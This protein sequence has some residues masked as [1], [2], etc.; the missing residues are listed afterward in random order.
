MRLYGIGKGA[1][2]AQERVVSQIL[3]NGLYAHCDAVDCIADVVE[4]GIDDLQPPLCK[5]AR[6]GFFGDHLLRDV[7]KSDHAASNAADFVEEGPPTYPDI[8][9]L[10]LFF[11]AYEYV[12][13]VGGLAVEY[14]AGERQVLC[15]DG[16]FLIG[17]KRAVCLRPFILGYIERPHAH[18]VFGCGVYVQ[19]VARFIGND[20]PITDAV[21]YGLHQL[22]LISQ[23]FDGLFLFG[24]CFFF[25]GEIAKNHQTGDD[26]IGYFAAYGQPTRT[27]VLPFQIFL[28]C[29]KNS[30]SS[31]SHPL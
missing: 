14:G 27:D 15:F 11:I 8:N 19:E 24:V 17:I 4:N 22:V 21:K 26:L 10:R 16:R 5:C 6:Q 1:E 12:L 29:T 25:F 18:N 13:F 20:D 2:A 7:V 3:V 30:I 23:F 9:A 28:F 31:V